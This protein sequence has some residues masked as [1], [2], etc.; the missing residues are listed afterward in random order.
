MKKSITQVL[1]FLVLVSC[2]T[3][4]T[5][6]A[7]GKNSDSTAAGKSAASSAL[8][9]A[10]TYRKRYGVE[11]VYT[12]VI[13]NRGEG[14]EDLYGLRN[15]R[16]VLHGVMYRGGANN[17]FHRTHPRDNANPLPEDGIENLCKEGFESGN[18]LYSTRYSS[19]SSKKLCEN[20]LSKTAHE[21]KY[22]NRLFDKDADVRKL[23]GE[24]H[25]I[26]SDGSRGPLYSH[27][28][29]GWHASGFLATVTLRQFCGVSASKAVEYWD[30]NTDGNNKNKR[31]EKI[32]E[33]IRK[34][35][36]FSE[37][38]IN[39]DIKKQICPKV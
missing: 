35:K 12:K 28:W 23:L 11:D 18:Y 36:P 27:C 37:L 14:F 2:A 26:A 3:G 15:L 7:P 38:K 29:N 32:R 22:T 31:Y 5:E 30:K 4:R 33:R 16:V 21:L 10:E 8:K 20:R 1:C 13:N 6:A 39:E 25:A 24:I 19:A 9:R 34:F 17:V